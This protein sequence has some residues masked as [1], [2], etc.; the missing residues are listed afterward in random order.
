MIDDLQLFR[1]GDYIINESITISHPTLNKI[2]D[3][4]EQK[5][6]AMVSSLCATP[7]DYKVFLLD[8][9]GV[10]YEDISEFE[11]FCTL[12]KGL[13]VNETSILFGDLDFG[14]FDL[15]Q[16]TQNGQ[17]VLFDSI[18]NIVIDD[19]LYQLISGYLRNIHNFEKRNDIAGNAH[20]KKYL[21]EKE[22]RKQQR[23]QKE[24]Y[25]SMLVPLVSAMVNCEQFKYD[26]NTVWDL[27]IYVFMDSVKRIQKLKN[28]N[29]LMQG[30]YAGT[31]DSKTLSQDSFNWMGSL[32]EN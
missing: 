18:H 27:P 14:C 7:S 16:N 26:H 1:G 13:S 28:Y 30:V 5:Y 29:Q 2:C 32:S 23:K 25:K 3:Y 10:D 31:I 8:N 22:R 4:G 9:F 21:I 15:A 17:T 24:N 11:F 19:A 20:T 12:C 6:Y